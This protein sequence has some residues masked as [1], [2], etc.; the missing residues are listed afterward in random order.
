MDDLI[1]LSRR[2]G[3][4]DGGVCPG[5]C[6]AGDGGVPQ[7]SLDLMWSGDD[8]FVSHRQS[9]T[10]MLISSHSRLSGWFDRGKSRV[11]AVGW[12]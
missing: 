6:A 7:A 3:R 12:L 9:R 5:R 2:H 4:F 1:V 11:D 10:L 8:C